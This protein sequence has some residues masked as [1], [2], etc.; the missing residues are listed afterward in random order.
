MTAISLKCTA[1]ERRR[2]TAF[3]IPGYVFAVRRFDLNDTVR[4]LQSAR[5]G[6]RSL[7]VSKAQQLRSCSYASDPSNLGK[8]WVMCVASDLNDLRAKCLAAWIAL[9]Q[10]RSRKPPAWTLWHTVTGSLGDAILDASADARPRA[11]LVVVANITQ[12]STQRRMERARDI[13]EVYSHVP[14]IVTATGIDSEAADPVA[15][16]N[17]LGY[18]CNHVVWLKSASTVGRESL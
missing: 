11:D 13:L 18:P 10:L 9:Q 7:R 5:P 14:R 4:S 1:E 16:M 6:R 17:R 12:W 15:V 8:P 3:G 2:L